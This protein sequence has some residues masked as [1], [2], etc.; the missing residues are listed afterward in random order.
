VL[1]YTDFLVFHKYL[2]HISAFYGIIDPMT[3]VTK[4]KPKKQQ[5]IA[6]IGFSREGQSILKFI[7]K[8]KQYRKAE[9]TILDKNPEIKV[10]RGVK[11]ITGPDYLNHVQNFHVIFRSPGVPFMRPEIQR[12]IKNNRVCSSATA[13]FFE[14]LLSLKKRPLIV[15]VTG[16]KGKGTT[17]T[18]IYECLKQAKVK[19]VL[20]GNIGKPM[21]DCL[22]AAKKAKVVI[23]ELSSFQLQDLKYSPDIAVV[24]SVTPDHM[25]AHQS[26]VE[27]Y[28]AKAQI[29]AHQTR[30]GIL[31]YLP[32]NIPSSEIAR[33]SIGKKSLIDPDQFTLFKQSDLKLRGKHNYANAVMAATVARTLGCSDEDIVKAV[34]KF[35]GLPYRLAHSHT[36]KI[37]PAAEVHF[38]NDSV[39]T[40]PETAAAAIKSFTEPMVLLAGGKDKRLDYG[41]LRNA[42]FR[43]PV[44]AVV[45]FGENRE[46]IAGGL[47]GLPIQIELKNSFEAAITTAATLARKK[48]VELSTT[49][50]VLF[51]PAA[52]SFDMF[53][54]MYD[55]GEQFDL[56][57]K[58]T[59]I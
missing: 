56:I 11:S 55:R 34:K 49:S 37:S 7:K 24:L 21:L 12:A 43:S 27:Y 6:I 36:A 46:K 19:T 48:A 45:L 29:A 52:A 53:K 50:V 28:N 38:Y 18:L 51:S 39:G 44:F 47:H 35:K 14:E 23:L 22:A 4:P 59:K 33:Q 42:L 15:G 10:P 20:A 57:V 40:N 30:D 5:K 9:I 17:S 31:Y 8:A 58:K 32:D 16:T 2:L 3:D 54:S 13:L 41:T 1:Y 26:L 25:D